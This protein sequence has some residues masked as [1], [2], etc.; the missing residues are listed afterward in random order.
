MGKRRTLIL[1]TDQMF[2]GSPEVSLEAGDKPDS[3]ATGPEKLAWLLTDSDKFLLESA[4]VLDFGHPA[5][6]CAVYLR[7]ERPPIAV[8][9]RPRQLRQIRRK[10]V[11]GRSTAYHDGE[12]ATGRS[13]VGALQAVTDAILDLDHP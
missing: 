13:R 9:T 2:P 11:V 6:T 10:R 5:L 8:D 12:G 7:A 1:S 3:K 4:A